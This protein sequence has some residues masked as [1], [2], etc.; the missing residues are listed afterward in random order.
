MIQKF[1]YGFIN[2]KLLKRKKKRYRRSLKFLKA[3][4]KQEQV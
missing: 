1:L 2:L 3:D 4:E